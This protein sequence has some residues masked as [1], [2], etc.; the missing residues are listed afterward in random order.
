MN[1]IDSS[2]W[3]ELIADAEYAPDIYEAA[4]DRKSL[5]V[6]SITLYEVYQKILRDFG[7]WQAT[8]A[9]AYMRK[10]T[11]VDL[12]ATLAIYAA[13]LSKK[14]DL[15]MA[16]SIIL[17]TARKHQALLWTMDADFKDID[18]VRYFEQKKRRR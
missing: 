14:Y 16:D 18:G 1:V 7:E 13:D 15:P 11:V 12:D 8:S 6:P 4:D 17:A 5:I 3:I 10:G 9:V 2:L